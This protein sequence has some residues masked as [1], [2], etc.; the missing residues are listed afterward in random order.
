MLTDHRFCRR[1]QRMKTEPQRIG[2][3]KLLQRINRDLTSEVWKASDTNTQNTVL[4]KFYRTNLPEDTTSLDYYVREV[5]RVAELHH[6]NFVRIHDVQV[7]TSHNANGG[8]TS[9]I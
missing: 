5:E 3:Y 6:P 8:P 9:L 1:S 7:L 4:L 2:Q